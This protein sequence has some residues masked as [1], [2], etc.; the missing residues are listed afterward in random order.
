MSCNFWKTPLHTCERMEKANNILVLFHQN[1]NSFD[2]EDSLKGLGEPRVTEGTECH[3][4]RV[5]R[6]AKISFSLSAHKP[7]YL[8]SIIGFLV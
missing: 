3:C 8:L 7:S 2:L 6:G 5:F 1:K 4:L